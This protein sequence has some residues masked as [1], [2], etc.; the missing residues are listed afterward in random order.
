MPLLTVTDSACNCC[1]CFGRRANNRGGTVCLKHAG[2]SQLPRNPTLDIAL[3]CTMVPVRLK[4]WVLLAPWLMEGIR[5]I[6][7]MT[8][9]RQ[10]HLLWF[11]RA[12]QARALVTDVQQSTLH[13]YST[14]LHH[15]EISQLYK[16]CNGSFVQQ[17]D[18]WLKYNT[19]N[20]MQFGGNAK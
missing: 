12:V 3:S 5:C 10:K 14:L 15:N 9:S 18:V 20:T 4:T 6:H 2:I 19:C 8:V 17:W 11:Q 1:V 7:D 16:A 13:Y